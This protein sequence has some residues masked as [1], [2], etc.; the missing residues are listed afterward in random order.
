MRLACLYP[1]ALCLARKP[2]EIQVFGGAE[3]GHQLLAV[4]AGDQHAVDLDVA[5]AEPVVWGDVLYG[6]DRAVHVASI[7]PDRRFQPAR[8]AMSLQTA[9]IAGR[10]AVVLRHTAPTCRTGAGFEKGNTT[11]PR[12]SP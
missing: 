12:A 1:D 5:P 3:I 7:M 9:S 8:S 10:R 11:T 4:L 2:H 6:C